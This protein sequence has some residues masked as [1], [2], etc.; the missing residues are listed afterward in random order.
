[1]II[2]RY[3]Y[4]YNDDIIGL[5]KNFHSEVLN[6]YGVSLN[7]DTLQNTIN[8]LKEQAFLLTTND[9]CQGL[10]AGRAV[11][12]PYSKD[13]IWHEVIWYVNKDYRKHGMWLLREAAKILKNEGYSKMVMVCMEN[14][15]DRISRVYE[16]LGFK[17]METHWIRSL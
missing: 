11:E 5:V 10:L 12:V 13:K 2:E 8:D 17:A 6:E 4:K 14:N 3:S 7:L 16:H 15:K 9:I 1:M